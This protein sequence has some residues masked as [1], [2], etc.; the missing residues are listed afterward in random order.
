MLVKYSE[1]G[2]V[3]KYRGRVCGAIGIHARDEFHKYVT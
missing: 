2:Y 3:E 1:D